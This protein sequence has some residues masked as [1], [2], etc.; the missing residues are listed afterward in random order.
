MALVVSIPSHHEAPSLL[1]LD[2]GDGYAG[3]AVG[4]AVPSATPVGGLLL[5]SFPV[6]G[7]DG[8][9][10]PLKDLFDTRHLFAATLHVLGVHLLGN[11]EALLC[12]DGGETLRLEHVDARLL[13]AQVGFEA[14]ED[15]RCVGA[16]VKD[17]GVPLSSFVSASHPRQ[18]SSSVVP[19][20]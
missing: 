10:G 9:D 20:P 8:E 19:C 18:G 12:C 13:V 1:L 6:V 3:V 2:D 16:K 14:D 7:H 4:D 15:E 17:F 5:E 11:G